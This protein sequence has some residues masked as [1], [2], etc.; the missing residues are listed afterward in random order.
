MSKLVMF[1]VSWLAYKAKYT[2][3]SLSF[4]EAPTGVIFGFLEQMRSTCLNPKVKS[5]RVGLFFDSRHSIRQTLYPEYKQKRRDSRTPDEI[6]EMICMKEQVKRLRCEILPDV[7]FP[8][9]I[10]NG[11]E[12]DDVMAQATNQILQGEHGIMITADGDLF[13]CIKDNVHWYD[14]SPARNLYLD[15]GTMRDTYGVGPNEWAE[16]KAIGGCDT[17]NVPGVAG[18]AEKT[19]IDYIWKMLPNGKRKDA[20]ESTEGQATIARNRK[21]VTLPHKSTNPIDITPPK[22]NPDALFKWGEKLGFKSYFDGTRRAAWESFFRGNVD[23]LER[24]EVR[25]RKQ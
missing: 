20:I 8:C 24:M 13:Q 16:V 14:P 25:Q 2:M 18:V 19:A 12:S 6:K 21:L 1:D 17:D 10:Q 9:F 4:E 11:L 5:S 23:V 15:V 22:Y 7:G 3:K